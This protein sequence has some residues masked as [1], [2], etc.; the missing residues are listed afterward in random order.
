MQENKNFEL[1]PDLGYNLDMIKDGVIIEMEKL[2]NYKKDK[3]NKINE[4]SK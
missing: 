3:K 2:T 4:K 1:S